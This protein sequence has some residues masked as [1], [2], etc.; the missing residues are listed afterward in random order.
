MTK[1]Y[2]AQPLVIECK[3]KNYQYFGKKINYA[4]FSRY[5]LSFLLPFG[6]FD[7]ERFSSIPEKVAWSCYVVFNLEKVLKIY[8]L[9]VNY[10]CIDIRKYVMLYRVPHGKVYILNWL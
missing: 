8:S 1:R 6:V 5:P 9:F 3:R 4:S 7:R 2:S 10:Y